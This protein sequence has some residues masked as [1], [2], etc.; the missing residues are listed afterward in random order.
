M[1]KSIFSVVFLFILCS[2]AKAQEIDVKVTS[3]PE[4]LKEN[5]NAVVRLNKSHIQVL[6]Q[7]KMAIQLTRVVTVLNKSGDTDVNA[8]VHYDKENKLKNSEAIVY[9]AFGEELKKIKQKDFKDQSAVDGVSLF[10]DNRILYLDYTPVTYPYTVAFTYEMETSNTAFI[11][12]WYPMEGYYIST[13]KSVFELDYLPELNIRFKEK[14]VEGFPIENQSSTTQLKYTASAIPA[15]KPETLSPLFTDV[16]PSVMVALQKFHLE[17]VDGEA[18]NWQEFGKWIHDNL[19]KGTENIPETTKNKIKTLVADK[20]TM[21]E[22]AEAVYKYLQENTR[23]ISIQV[24]IGGWKPMLASDVDKLGYG[25]CKALTNYTKSL[26]EAAG[27]PSH[28]TVVYGDSDKKDIDAQFVSMQGNHVILAIPDKDGLVFL[29]CTSQTTPF[30]FQAGFTDDRAVLVVTPEGGEIKKTKAYLNEDNYQCTK[31]S[32]TILEDG[33]ITAEI[34]IK[35]TGNQYAY[36]YEQ[37]TLSEEDKTKSY[38][39]Y[40]NYINN[41]KVEKISHANDK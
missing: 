19:L 16:A 5:A 1:I 31:A 37:E 7:R 33:T 6:S 18:S 41:L 32:Y 39:D 24:G 15:V 3:I 36:R 30:G 35:T 10:T 17:G 14:N 8:Y 34:A 23:Y 27:I 26:L 9:D 20:E 2:R 21:L 22:K 25:D 13:E 38:K 4:A 11:P 12:N 28:Y 40:W 29:E